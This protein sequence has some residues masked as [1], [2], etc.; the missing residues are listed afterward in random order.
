VRFKRRQLLYFLIAQ[1]IIQSYNTVIIFIIFIN[2]SK[3]LE[4]LE[5]GYFLYYVFYCKY[6]RNKIVLIA[7]IFNHSVNDNSLKFYIKREI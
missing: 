7:F 4:S 5:I 6:T 1:N 2:Y 3:L